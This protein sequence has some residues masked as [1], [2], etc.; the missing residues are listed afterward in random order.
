MA[1]TS[2]R[3]RGRPKGSIGTRSAHVRA[4]L[5]REFGLEPARELAK[6]CMESDDPKFRAQC[7]R[8]L[9]PYCYPKLASTEVTG[10]DGG[11]LS[12][13]IVLEPHDEPDGQG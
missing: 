11:A 2:K 12:V 3:S 10:A 5:D 1:E 13:S 8:D 9:L 6:L 7:A 4:L